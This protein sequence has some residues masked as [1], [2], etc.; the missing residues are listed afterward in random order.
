MP[1]VPGSADHFEAEVGDSW[2]KV[3]AGRPSG[4]EATASH[5][6]FLQGK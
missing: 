6:S 2:S 5:F 4:G 1:G 3:I